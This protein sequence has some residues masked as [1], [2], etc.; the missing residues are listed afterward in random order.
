MVSSVPI[1]QRIEVLPPR[2]W[3]ADLAA[4]LSAHSDWP[5]HSTIA[6][7]IRTLFSWPFTTLF[8]LLS[9][10]GDKNE[11]PMIIHMFLQALAMDGRW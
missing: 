2:S 6:Q 10:S 4:N 9:I 3:H 5:P 1:D 8:S 7:S 11:E